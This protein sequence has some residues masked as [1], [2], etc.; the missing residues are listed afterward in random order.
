MVLLPGLRPASPGWRMYGMAQCSWFVSARGLRVAVDTGQKSP[1]DE[2]RAA[3]TD[4]GVRE[5]QDDQT[6]CPRLGLCVSD[7]GDAGD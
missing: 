7:S 5:S 1:G 3:E 6:E 4:S 2:P